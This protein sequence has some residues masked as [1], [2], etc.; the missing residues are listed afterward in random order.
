MPVRIRA[1]RDVYDRSTST[2]DHCGYEFFIVTKRSL[3]RNLHCHETFI[4]TKADRKFIADTNRRM[5]CP[6]CFAQDAPIA[7]I[8]FPVPAMPTLFTTMFI[9]LK[10]SRP[11]RK[12]LHDEPAPLRSPEFRKKARWTRRFPA[13][14]TTRA[15]PDRSG[16]CSQARRRDQSARRQFQPRATFLRRGPSYM[17]ERERDSHFNRGRAWQIELRRR[18]PRWQC[19]VGGLPPW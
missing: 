13:D 11:A 6:I 12:T 4:V 17:R 14:L 1:R 18:N 7:S 19:G 8:R 10:L 9:R 16:R 2:S 5:P 3:S 15:A